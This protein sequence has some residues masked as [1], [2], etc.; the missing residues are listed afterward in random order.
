[1]DLLKLADLIF[2]LFSKI[3]HLDTV[4]ITILLFV[5]LL[6]TNWLSDSIQTKCNNNQNLDHHLDKIDFHRQCRLYKDWTLLLCCTLYVYDLYFPYFIK[7]LKV[8]K[9]EHMWELFRLTR[10]LKALD[11]CKL[12]LT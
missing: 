6:N 4:N 3:S 7:L 5:D 8:L 10:P 12:K 9:S 2:Y 11:I 1:M